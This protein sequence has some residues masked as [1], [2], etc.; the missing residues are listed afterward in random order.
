MKFAKQLRAWRGD[1][2]QAAAAKALGVSLRNYQNWEIGH[3]TPKGFALDILLQKISK[4]S[5]R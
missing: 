5:R 2:T 3:R 1:R 4:K